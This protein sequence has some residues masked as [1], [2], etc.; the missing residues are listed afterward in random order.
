ML[1]E[2]AK[3]ASPSRNKPDTD[4]LWGAGPIGKEIGCNRRQA[5]HLLE[6]GRLPAKKIGGKWVASRAVLRQALIG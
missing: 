6:T 5:F 2:E 1:S 4:I 3:E